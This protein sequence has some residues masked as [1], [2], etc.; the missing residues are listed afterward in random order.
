MFEGVSMRKRAFTLIELLVVVAIIALL[1]AILIPSLGKA[2]ETTRRTTCAA[3]LKGQGQGFAIYA[4]E[5]SDKVPMFTNTT[6]NWLHD[7]P[8]EIADVLL[9]GAASS[10]ATNLSGMD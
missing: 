7:Q 9:K 1:I 4:A 8:F 2:R 5:F 3:N 10:S 6:S